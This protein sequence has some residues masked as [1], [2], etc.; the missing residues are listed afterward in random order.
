[1]TPDEVM[2]NSNQRSGIWESEVGRQR[3]L[4]SDVAKRNVPT[5]S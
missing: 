4:R 2:S 3:V 1:M 5:P